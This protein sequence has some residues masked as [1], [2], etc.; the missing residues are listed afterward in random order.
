MPSNKLFNL[1]LVGPKQVRGLIG[2]GIPSILNAFP[3]II[4]VSD[5]KI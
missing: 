3:F 1:S 4:L 5:L 2:W